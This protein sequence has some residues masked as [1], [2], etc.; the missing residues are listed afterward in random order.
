MQRKAPPRGTKAGI[1]SS[2]DLGTW[3]L[4]VAVGGQ[5]ERRQYRVLADAAVLTAECQGES[6]A[7]GQCCGQQHRQLRR[8]RHGLQDLH[9]GAGGAEE[10]TGQRGHGPHVAAGT[11]QPPDLGVETGWSGPGWGREPWAHRGRF[12]LVGWCVA[13]PRQGRFC[14][15]LHG[16][17]AVSSRCFSPSL[18]APP[19]F[20]AVACSALLPSVCLPTVLLPWPSSHS[21]PHP[22]R[23]KLQARAVGHALC[24]APLSLGPLGLRRGRP[25][26]TSSCWA[27]PSP[28]CRVWTPCLGKGGS[29]RT[30][31]GL[32]CGRCS[33]LTC[34]RTQ[35]GPWRCDGS[36][37][38]VSFAHVC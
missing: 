3:P 14:F 37:A 31:L 12:G 33:G 28:G 26:A 11:T 24:P 35:A 17:R 1:P 25:F 15:S 10:A 5:R 4:V 16:R 13:Q 32:C 21:E 36:E 22:M 29:G 7:R 2:C 38:C 27:S 8:L 19:A 20:N 23:S 9:A 34:G 30:R 6:G 18:T